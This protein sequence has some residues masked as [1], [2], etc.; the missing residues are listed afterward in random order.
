MLFVPFGQGLVLNNCSVYSIEDFQ[1]EMEFRICAVVKD[2]FIYGKKEM[3]STLEAD[4]PTLK[5][6]HFQLVHLGNSIS[7]FFVCMIFQS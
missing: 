4:T 1:R 7:I 2:G 3:F 6:L 5:Y